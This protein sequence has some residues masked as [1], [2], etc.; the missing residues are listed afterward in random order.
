M[1]H[2]PVIAQVSRNSRW[3]YA[4]RPGKNS[5]SKHSV[6]KRRRALTAGLAFGLAFA[7]TPSAAWA[8]DE[9]PEPIVTVEE[10]TPVVEPEVVESD[11]VESP[12]ILTDDAEPTTSHDLAEPTE[13][14]QPEVVAEPEQP[15]KSVESETPDESK[16][17]ES[18]IVQIETDETELAA[19]ES[20]QPTATKYESFQPFDGEPE[21]DRPFV[22]SRT[23]PSG[24]L[25]LTG[26]QTDRYSDFVYVTPTGARP[27]TWNFDSNQLPAG[28]SFV[29]QGTN[30]EPRLQ[31]VGYPTEAGTFTMTVTATNNLGISSSPATITL[32]VLKRPVNIIG[33]DDDVI[34][35][36]G[37][38]VATAHMFNIT[39]DEYGVGTPSFDIPISCQPS[40]GGSAGVGTINEL[41]GEVTVTSPGAFCIR[42]NTSETAT[43][44]VGSKIQTLVVT[45]PDGSSAPVITTTSLSNA[46]TTDTTYYVQLTATSDSPVTWDEILEHVVG[47]QYVSSLPPNL[48]LNADGTFTV[49]GQ[50]VAG[51]YSFRVRASSTAGT[52]SKVL[53]ITINK[54]PVSIGLTG[55]SFDNWYGQYI[56]LATLF[57]IP[58]NTGSIT[59]E[60]IVGTGYREGNKFWPSVAGEYQIKATVAETDTH[61]AATAIATLIVT[62]V[63]AP[64]ITTTSLPDAFFGDTLYAGRFSASGTGP[65]TW[66]LCPDSPPLPPNMSLNTDGT[67]SVSGPLALGTY[68]FEAYVSNSFAGTICNDPSAQFS[69]AIVPPQNRHQTDHVSIDGTGLPWYVAVRSAAHGSGSA[70]HSRLLANADGELLYAVEIWL[71]D[72]RTNEVWQPAPGQLVNV[73]ITGFQVPTGA[74]VSVLHLHPTNGPTVL[75]ATVS[76]GAVTF[77]SDH[78]SPFGLVKAMDDGDSGNNGGKDNNSGNTGN[79]G[80]VNNNGGNTGNNGDSS[81]NDANTTGNNGASTNSE[82][83]PGNTNSATIPLPIT[84]TRANA[85]PGRVVGSRTSQLMRTGVATSGLVAAVLLVS[86]GF[87]AAIGTFGG[88]KG[89]RLPGRRH[90]AA[91][92]ARKRSKHGRM[93]RGM[94]HAK[95]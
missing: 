23:L 33:S 10:I 17:S 27:Y 29:D 19:N 64:S 51:A 15:T 26:T 44:R 72:L 93:G 87:G 53:S 25:N 57:T 24:T 8:N 13:P 84:G 37:G 16:V 73:T 36:D 78:F 79:N 71:V 89:H 82:N 88:V 65:L 76:N 49:T 66:K 80:I 61:A 35:W 39:T 90:R 6:C 59:Y 31:I 4:S 22:E 34:G 74:E 42:M 48:T 70:T 32:T 3:G 28:L 52:S 47:G 77:A 11:V 30:T 14:K 67:F 7:G 50:L 12:E 86:N 55:V 60:V 56:D 58:N 46:V 2:L 95:K 62:K 63:F 83:G 75:N 21:P 85:N 91:G 92:S 18:G 94:S 54:V 38:L 40:H 69:I 41:T 68:Q 5:L 45:A 1:F 81:N 43:H 9:V 20:T